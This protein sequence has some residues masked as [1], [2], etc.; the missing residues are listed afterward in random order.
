MIFKGVWKKPYPEHDCPIGTGSQ[1]PPQQI[2]LD[3]LVTTTICAR[4]GLAEDSTCFMVDFFL[5]RGEVAGTPISRT[6]CTGGAAL[7]NRTVPR[8]SVRHG[9]VTTGRAA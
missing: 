8:A 3:E 6:A 5:S 7:R 4:A 9:R 2:R 1:I